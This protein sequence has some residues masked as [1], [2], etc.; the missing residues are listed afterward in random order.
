MFIEQAYKGTKTWWRVL[1]TTIC[2]AG[3]FVGNFIAFFMMS[4]E[5]IEEVYKSMSDVPNNVSLIMNLS[6]FVLLLGLLFLLVRNI[7]NR[8]VLSLTTSRNKID[9][10]R[11]LFSFSLVVFLT[12]VVFVATF[13]ID[14]SNI[15]W[16][17]NLLKFSLLF[18]IS[19]VL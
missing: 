9:Y 13:F 5:Q 12:I 6:P 2:T 17:F 7:H 10:K 19:V 18:L 8:S 4:T 16:N 3:I 11:I 14:H 15:V 1:S